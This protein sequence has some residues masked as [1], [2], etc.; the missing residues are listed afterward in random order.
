MVEKVLLADP[1]VLTTYDH[2]ASKHLKQKVNVKLK[3]EKY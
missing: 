2:L 3:V 1:F